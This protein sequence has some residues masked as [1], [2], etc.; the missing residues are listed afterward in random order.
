MN[1]LQE[2]IHGQWL[3]CS[4][5]GI[6]RADASPRSSRQQL[7]ESQHHGLSGITGNV[8]YAAR[9]ERLGRV[10]SVNAAINAYGTLSGSRIDRSSGSLTPTGNP[11]DLAIA[12]EGFFAVQARDKVLYTRNGS[13]HRTPEGLLASSEGNPVLGEQ[14]RISLPNGS[15]AVSSDG[16]VSVGGAVVAKL[17]IVEF[18]PAANLQAAETPCTQ[19]QRKLCCPPRRRPFARR[20][21]N[22]RT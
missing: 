20:C 8:P 18:S 11:L 4:V 12:G 19:R 16:T 5:R 17:R 3:L 9:R 13:F 22:N 21:S 15:V 1:S 7:G 14:G 10:S 2:F 6:G